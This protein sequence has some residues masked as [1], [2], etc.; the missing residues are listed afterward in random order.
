MPTEGKTSNLRAEFTDRYLTCLPDDDHDP[1]HLY[2]Y[3]GSL[4]LSLKDVR[5]NGGSLIQG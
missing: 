3:L 5:R 2:V 4:Y 1:L